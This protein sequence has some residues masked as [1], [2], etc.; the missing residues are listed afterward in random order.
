MHS[1]SARCCHKILTMWLVK[2]I[3]VCQGSLTCS[4]QLPFRV[5]QQLIKVALEIQQSL[6][7]LELLQKVTV[8]QLPKIPIFHICFQED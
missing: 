2:V 1:W 7:T 4:K 5:F 8:P 3:F 6:V